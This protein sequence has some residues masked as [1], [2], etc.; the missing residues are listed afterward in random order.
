[1]QFFGFYCG[2]AFLIYGYNFFKSNYDCKYYS[3]D[4]DMVDIK[5]GLMVGLL[6]ISTIHFITLFLSKFDS[7]FLLRILPSLPYIIGYIALIIV[8]VYQNE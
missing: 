5:F 7:L 3:T 6:I 2:S 4:C 8:T 1:M